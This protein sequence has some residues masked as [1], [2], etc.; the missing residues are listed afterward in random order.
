M[1]KGRMEAFSDGVLAIIITIMVLELK[2]PHDATPNALIPLIPV[3]LSYVL[4]FVFVGIYWNNHHHLLQAIRHVDGAVLWA[5]LHLLFWLSLI[6]FVTAWMGE[7]QFAPWPVALYGVVLLF[8][9]IA[10]YILARALIAAHGTDSVLATA[11]GRDVKGK[12]SVVAYAAAIP[13]ALA[14]SWLA[15][16]LFVLVAIMWLVPDRRIEKTL[17]GT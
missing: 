7:N 10:Y 11:L 3:V 2:V 16:G 12:V 15:F 1:T 6:P 4:S 5:N 14:S 13:L 9:S 8:A 17:T